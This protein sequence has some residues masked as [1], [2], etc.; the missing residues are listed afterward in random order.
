[1][2]LP[3]AACETRPEVARLP[4]GRVEVRGER[5]LALRYLTEARD[6]CAARADIHA[7]RRANDDCIIAAVTLRNARAMRNPPP[8]CWAVPGDVRCDRERVVFTARPEEM[9]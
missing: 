8:G 9:R 2:L 1:M 3:L 6:E 4:D 5:A 7:N